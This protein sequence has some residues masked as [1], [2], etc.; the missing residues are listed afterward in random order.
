MTQLVDPIT[1]YRS[2][3]LNFVKNIHEINLSCNT[4]IETCILNNLEHKAKIIKAKQFYLRKISLFLQESIKKLDL[5][6]QSG[7]DKEKKQQKIEEMKK[8][9]ICID[10]DIMVD[11]IGQILHEE[12]E[13][14]FIKE[15]ERALQDQIRSH[16]NEIIFEL[17]SQTDRIKKLNEDSAHARRKYSKHKQT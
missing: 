4:G 8:T 17:Q 5:L 16:E 7:D 14:G 3:L 11:D 15:L 9:W 6:M 12:D 10:K 1:Q 2:E 13:S